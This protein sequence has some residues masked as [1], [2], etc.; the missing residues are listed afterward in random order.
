M[1]DETKNRP[2]EAAQEPQEAP[3][4]VVSVN[5]QAD[6]KTPQEA[7]QRPQEGME[8]T[9]RAGGQP[10]GGVEPIKIESKRKEKA[11]QDGGTQTTQATKGTYTHT[12]R[13]PVEY[14]E[15]TFKTLTFYWDRLNGNDMI[16][17]ENE[18]QEMNEYALSPEI[19]ASFLSRMAAKAAGVGPD[20]MEGLPIGEFS[21]IKNE[22][23]NFLISTGY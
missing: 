3:D 17:I 1:A 15:K 4:S 23:R 19:S 22:A 7:A 13:R 21:K 11:P 18:M 6:K 5:G 20:F 14:E 2:A 12:F 10:E 9:A 8:E 16:S